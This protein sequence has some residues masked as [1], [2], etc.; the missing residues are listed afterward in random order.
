M[1]YFVSLFLALFLVGCG[2]QLSTKQIVDKVQNGVVVISN[3]NVSDPKA[4]GLGTGFIVGENEIVTNNHVIEGEGNKLTVYSPN[5][6]TMY[7]AEVVH[8]DVVSDV[9]VI[10][11][12]DWE[13]FKQAEMPVYIE[14]GNSEEQD[15][16]EK[17]VVVG[18]PWG[19]TWSVS[20][21][22]TSQKNRRFDPNPKYVDQVDAKLFQGN[23]GGPIFNEEGQV[24]C[25][26]N[27]MMTREGGSYGFCL[28]TTLVNKVLYD[29]K[30]LGE[31]RWRAM[32]VSV[33]QSEEKSG[34]V[35]KA[36]EPNGAAAAAGLQVDDL[37]L[38]IITPNNHP[39]GIIVRSPDDVITE[40]ATLR[41]DDENVKMV[42][43]RNGKE[44]VIDV[45]TN[46][47]LSKDY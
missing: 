16:G 11:L 38:K 21:G 29:F 19:L 6:R 43:E 8:T 37:V 30:T 3:Q 23:S 45:K 46:Y 2:S 7:D 5:S 27:L 32:N 17:V 33:S 25:I 26:S 39:E 28:P 47:K 1:R 31:V 34:V 36:L 41:G 12:K 20:E 22:I 24:I 18:H 14:I 35:I 15:L 10:K 4:S 42:V 44:L 13:K 40:L 9:A